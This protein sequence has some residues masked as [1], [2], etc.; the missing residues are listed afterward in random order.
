M[1]NIRW[2]D[3]SALDKVRL[4]VEL[5]CELIIFVFLKLF[6]ASQRVNSLAEVYSVLKNILKDRQ[7]V[8]P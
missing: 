6:C 1:Q 3:S 2:P 4:S 7:N 8:L 5:T